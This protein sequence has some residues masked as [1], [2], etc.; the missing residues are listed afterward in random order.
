M[1]TIDYKTTGLTR[2]LSE[3]SVAGLMAIRKALRLIRDDQKDIIIVVCT[4]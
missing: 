4:D 1:I 2:P 3:S